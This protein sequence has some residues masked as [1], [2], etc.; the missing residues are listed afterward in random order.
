MP[1]LKRVAIGLSITA[2]TLI[3]YFYVG[4][5]FEPWMAV[6]NGGGFIL[7]GMWMRRN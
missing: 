3:G 2:L 7:G 6:V 4:E 5:W 1:A